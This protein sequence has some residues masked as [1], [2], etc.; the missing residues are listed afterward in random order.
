MAAKSKHSKASHD[1]APVAEVAA[2]DFEQKFAA[3]ELERDEFKDQA[4]RTLA[5][6]QNYRR[7]MANERQQGRL[8]AVEEIA[9]ALLPI[10]DNFERALAAAGQAQDKEAVVAGVEM[11]N[12]QLQSVLE[13][14]GVLPIQAIGKPFDPNFHEA[15]LTTE[16]EDQ[17]HD[18][19]LEEL[20]R[21]YVLNGKVIRASRVRVAKALPKADG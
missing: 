14:A 12:K 10:V 17:E 8:D 3:L 16:T 18:T 13:T 7:R 1:P 6:F 4:L 19:V 11:I 21:G 2:Q 20:E 5:E 9:R 15:I